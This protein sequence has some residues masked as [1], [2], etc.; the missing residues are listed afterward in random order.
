MS[1]TTATDA[2]LY[3]DQIETK[4]LDVRRKV[5]TRFFVRETL[6]TYCFSVNFGEFLQI[7]FYSTEVQPV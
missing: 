1:L 7:F 2:F 5:R 6:P 3:A 4:F